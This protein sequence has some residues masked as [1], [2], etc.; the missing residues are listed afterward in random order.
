MKKRK[1]IAIAAI[2]GLLILMVLIY[3]YA[4]LPLLEMLK[5][6]EVLREWSEDG[7]IGHRIAFVLMVAMQV[8]VAIIPG[9][10]FEIAAGAI[11]G[12]V[13]GTILCLVGSAVGGLIAFWLAKRFGTK[14]LELFFDREQID[15]VAFLRDAKRLRLVTAIVFL[16]PGTPK[17]ILTYGAGLTKID[18]ASFLLISTLC[19]LPSIVSSTWGGDALLTG[20]LKLAG[21]ILVA[22]LII[23]GLGLLVYRKIT[24][25]KASK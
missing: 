1:R 13:E 2:A 14:V 12:A 6:P 4:G 19:K 18:A 16:I 25:R 24:A 15:S 9:E 8:V 3:R 21:L 11:Y 5:D 20:N 17:D 7:G 22:T 10:P 23:S